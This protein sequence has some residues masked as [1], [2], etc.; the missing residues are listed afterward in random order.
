MQD[1]L[2]DNIALMGQ[3]SL[4][5]GTLPL[6]PTTIQRTWLREVPSLASWMYCFAAYVAIHT[7]DDLT[8]R[9]LAYAHLIIREALRHG[10]SGWAEYEFS[11]GKCQLTQ[12]CPGTHLSPASKLPLF[13]A[14]T[15]LTGCCAPYAKKVTTQTMCYG[16]IPATTTATPTICHACSIIPPAKAP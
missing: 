6:P 14:N 16:P 5:H 7:P 2:A 3:L 13:S 1:L 15:V 11:G 4:L 8:R 12:R 9:M 10:S